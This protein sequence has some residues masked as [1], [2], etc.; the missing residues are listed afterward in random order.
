MLW[1]P[2]MPGPIDRII[3]VYNGDSGLGAMLLDVLKKAAGRDDCALCAITYSPVGKR[4]A[5]TACASRLGIPV[6]ELHRDELPPAWGITRAQLPCVLGRVGE[7]QPFVLL[8]RTEI[9]GLGRSVEGLERQLRMALA[10]HDAAPPRVQ[11]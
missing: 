9:E 6:E 1:R 8:T 4:R 7:A 3:L 2:F 10:A 11:R 5:W